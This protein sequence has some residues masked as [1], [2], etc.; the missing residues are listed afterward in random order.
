MTALTAAQIEAAL[1]PARE[2]SAEAGKRA[3]RNN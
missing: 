1:G 3:P 2:A